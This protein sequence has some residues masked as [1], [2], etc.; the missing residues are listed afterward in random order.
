MLL[1]LVLFFR[2]YEEFRLLYTNF[3]D[4]NVIVILS[5]YVF[6]IYFIHLDF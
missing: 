5:F 4:E 6:S 2:N 1:G 3:E